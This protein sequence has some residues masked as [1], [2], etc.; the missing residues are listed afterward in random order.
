M[1]VQMTPCVETSRCIDNKIQ[2]Q[3]ELPMRGL[4]SPKPHP[5]FQRIKLLRRRANIGNFTSPNLSYVFKYSCVPIVTIVPETSE[6]LYKLIALLTEY[7]IVLHSF[8]QVTFQVLVNMQR[9][10]FYMSNGSLIGLQDIYN[11]YGTEPAEENEYS[12]SY[13]MDPSG[14]EWHTDPGRGHGGRGKIVASNGWIPHPAE[15]EKLLWMSE[16]DLFT[17][18]PN[19]NPEAV[20]E[21]KESYHSLASLVNW[22]RLLS[23]M[24]AVS[25]LCYTCNNKYVALDSNGRRLRWPTAI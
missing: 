21:S 7:A 12:P 20:L 11:Y 8:F 18:H 4:Y 15:V 16:P 3:N 10:G 5:V 14:R 9:F 23:D 24:T 6:Y 25:V 17:N 2:L 1:A 22:Q 19:S 13:T